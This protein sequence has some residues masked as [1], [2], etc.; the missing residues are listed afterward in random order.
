DDDVVQV[1]DDRGDRELPLE[2]DRQVD[3]DADDDERER[4]G[5]ILR[6][7]LADL[8]PYDLAA[9]QS[10]RFDGASGAN[11]ARRGLPLGCSAFL[12][13]DGT[14]L[15]LAKRIENTGGE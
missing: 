12:R 4:L 7:L 2:A 6:Q 15:G 5:P 14:A 1:G 9:R 10:Q 8:R 11:L 3:H 13:L